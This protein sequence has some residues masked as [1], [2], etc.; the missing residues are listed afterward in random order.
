MLTKYARLLKFL[1]HDSHGIRTSEDSHG[2]T[3]M[4]SLHARSH[5]CI[6]SVLHRLLHALHTGRFA[7]AAVI[8]TVT[9]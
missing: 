8:F 5:L 4:Q 2:G 3:D 1:L 6:T 9:W 7:I